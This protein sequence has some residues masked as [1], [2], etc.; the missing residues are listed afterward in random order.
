MSQPVF[1][2]GLPVSPPMSLSTI[3]VSAAVGHGSERTSASMP[4]NGQLYL[5]HLEIQLSSIAG[6]ATKVTAWFTWDAAGDEYCQP[7]V[8]SSINTG[9]TTATKGTALWGIDSFMRIPEGKT[10]Y[11]W[12][13]LNAGTANVSAV[14]AYWY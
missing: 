7:P 3:A 2:S 1:Y 10:L 9:F 6:G 8:E 5:D 4:G 11:L 14:R 13:K 12:A